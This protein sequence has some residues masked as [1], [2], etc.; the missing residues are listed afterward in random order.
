MPHLFSR[1]QCHGAGLVAMLR[2][3][4]DPALAA[5]VGRAAE[6][7][8]VSTSE[9]MRRRL[10]A[11]LHDEGDGPDKPFRPARGQRPVPEQAEA[12]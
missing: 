11:A 10:R 3:R 4:A 5:A 6:Q 12:A 2:F 1:K 7:E 8:G 9:F